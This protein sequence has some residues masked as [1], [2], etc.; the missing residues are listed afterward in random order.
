MSTS[1]SPE[2]PGV[3]RPDF[4]IGTR[5]GTTCDTEFAELVERFL[6]DLG[7]RV[8]ID[9]PYKGMELVRRYSDPLRGR[10][11]LQLEINRRLYM[12]ESRISKNEGFATLKA[13][14][15]GLVESICDYAQARIGARL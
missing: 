11:S 6:S 9:D 4:C 14:M 13:H 15:T 8:T 1:V 12:D 7:Y 10:H 5:D 3:P 2:G